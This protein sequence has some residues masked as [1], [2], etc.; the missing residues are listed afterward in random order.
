MAV[1]EFIK[2]LGLS[3]KQWVYAGIFLVFSGLLVALKL[4]DNELHQFQ[5][6]DMVEKFAAQTKAANDAVEAAKKKYEE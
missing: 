4:K 1:I 6:K 3:L 2:G 5:V